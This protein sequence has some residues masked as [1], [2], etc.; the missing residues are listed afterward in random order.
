MILLL[1]TTWNRVVRDAPP[2]RGGQTSAVGKLQRKWVRVRRKVNILTSGFAK[3]SI[4]LIESIRHRSR[5]RQS[6]Q[7]GVCVIEV[8][9]KIVIWVIVD[10]SCSCSALPTVLG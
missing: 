7:Q 2:L 5:W 10:R 9:E 6:N 8:I 3:K 1:S 4:I